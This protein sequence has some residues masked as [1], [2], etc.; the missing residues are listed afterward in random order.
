[1][2]QTQQHPRKALVWHQNG[3]VTNPSPQRQC[4]KFTTQ[5]TD[6]QY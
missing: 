6:Q 2:T 3:A 4:L 1:M 5:L